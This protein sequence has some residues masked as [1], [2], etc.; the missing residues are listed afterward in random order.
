MKQPLKNQL[1]F[2]EILRQSALVDATGSDIMSEEA[3]EKLLDWALA[4]DFKN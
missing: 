1:R 2:T 4:I 3:K